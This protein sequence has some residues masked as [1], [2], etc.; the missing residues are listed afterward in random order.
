MTQP[1]PEETVNAAIA[2][3]ECALVEPDRANEI[4]S[5]WLRRLANAEIRRIEKRSKR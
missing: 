1:D 3:I 4:L 2:G 5:E